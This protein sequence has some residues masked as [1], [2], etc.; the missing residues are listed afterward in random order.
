MATSEEAAIPKAIA[1][2]WGLDVPGGR[3]PKRGLTLDQ[4][5][6]AAVEVADAEGY[7]ALSMN[8]VATQLGFTAMSLY[9]YV[10]SK[11]TLV[12]LLLDRVVGTPPTIA[13]DTPWREAL[14][15]W[16]MAE[17]AAIERHPWWLDI[18]LIGPPMGP[19]NMQWL[20]TGLRALAATEIPVPVR[21]QLV[22]NLSFFV[23]G[24]MRLARGLTVDTGGE[25][26]YAEVMQRLI[27]PRRYPN[28][29]A[30]LS[31]D[32]LDD[33]IDWN[34]AD[35]EFGLARLLDGYESFVRGL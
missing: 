26:D 35:F 7:Q 30:A 29:V 32:S 18:P 33:D 2:L 1:L 9:R 31:S 23:M 24:R 19:N 10:D 14:W 20:E 13:P 28:V 8:R 12:D 6:D 34:R 17:Y 25:D 11:Q 21:M 27:D 22:M 16:A 15:Q 3:G 4:I 5:L